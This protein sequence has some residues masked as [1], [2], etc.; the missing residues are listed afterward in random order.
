MP[1]STSLD[2]V[3]IG[4]ALTSS[5][6][7][8][9]ATTYRSLLKGLHGLGHRV[10]FLEKDQPWYAAHRDAPAVPYCDV[11]LYGDCEDLRA[12]F[13]RRIREADVVIVGSYVDQGIDVCNWVL[14][15]ARGIRAFYDIDTP[16]TLATLGQEKCSYLS[17]SQVGQFDMVLSFSGGAI[18]HTLMHRFGARCAKALYCSVDPEGYRPGAASPTIDLGYMGTYSEDRQEGLQRLLNEPARSLTGMQFKVVG[19]QYPDGIDWPRNVTHVAHLGPHEHE[20][21]YASQRFT[22]NVTRENM[23]KAGHS[24][25]VRLFEAAA[26]GTPIISDDWPGLEEFFTPGEEILIAHDAPEVIK[27]L[28][29]IPDRQRQRMAMHARERVLA[30]HTGASRARELERHIFACGLGNAAVT[31]AQ[32]IATAPTF[33]T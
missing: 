20:A 14:E 12:R 26:C 33:S 3:V 25:S 8:G 23:R 2:I 7:N 16:V 5:W 29:T 10:L 30:L 28:T 11:Q 13:D 4:L 31:H 1:A 32:P 18:L 21:F 9:H 17:K 19:A 24:P 6:G 27:F 22:L 15:E